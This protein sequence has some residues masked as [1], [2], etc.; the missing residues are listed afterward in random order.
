MSPFVL[1][2]SKR[3]CPRAAALHATLI[4]SL[5]ASSAALGGPFP[6][7]QYL[8]GNVANTE[9]LNATENLNVLLGAQGQSLSSSY[10]IMVDTTGVKRDAAGSPLPRDL[11]DITLAGAATSSINQATVRLNPTG[12]VSRVQDS[13]SWTT[14]PTTNNPGTI[15]SATLRVTF[16]SHVQVTDASVVFSSLNTAGTTWEYSVL[17]FLDPAGN[18]FSSITGP[19]WSIG[20]AGQYL[21]A[22][23]SS[24]FT[25]QAGVGNYVAASTGTV[26]NVGTNQTSGGS[27]GS[28]DNVT[29]TYALAG[30]AAGTQ[31]G[32]WEWSSYLEDVRG[33]A[34]T[35]SSNFTSSMTS[36]T[37]TGIAVPEPSA[38]VMLGGGVLCAGWAGWRRR[39]RG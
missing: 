17:R 10:D 35:S 25:G 37:I 28:S 16:A 11:V 6:A 34:N 30:L 9:V 19:A 14:T 15:A 4:G 22:A 5:A 32:G 36:F 31:I 21:T 24:G 29:L 27:S 7:T 18:Y 2:V 20:D 26:Q 1:D 38:V 39:R 3:F 12:S 13:L 8:G 33:T 23:G